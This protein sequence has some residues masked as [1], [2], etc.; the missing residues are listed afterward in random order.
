MRRFNDSELW[1]DLALVVFEEREGTLDTIAPGGSETYLAL[2]VG[3]PV[4]SR[5]EV[6]AQ[7][8]TGSTVDGVWSAYVVMDNADEIWSDDV[9]QPGVDRRNT[10][11]HG[12][13]DVE[14]G[15]YSF[16]LRVD[17]DAGS[18][19]DIDVYSRTLLIRRGRPVPTV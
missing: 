1:D 9:R 14:P 17:V 7:V 16:S 12:T 19:N 5:L 15:V 13:V 4:T 3:C 11:W 10:A 6:H 8:S 2:E 18:A